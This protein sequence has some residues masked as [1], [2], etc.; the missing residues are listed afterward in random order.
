LYQELNQPK[1]IPNG[2]NGALL[3]A[4]SHSKGKRMTKNQK[5]VLDPSAQF[6]VSLFIPLL[7]FRQEDLRKGHAQLFP[8]PTPEVIQ[9]RK[10]NLQFYGLSRSTRNLN[11][12]KSHVT[13]H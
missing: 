9:A 4:A 2:S 13:K 11:K 6:P 7:E 5:E 12:G 1:E 8:A 10:S 3:E